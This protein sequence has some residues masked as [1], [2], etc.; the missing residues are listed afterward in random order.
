[1]NRIHSVT[2]ALATLSAAWLAAAEPAEEID[3]LAGAPASGVWKSFSEN[4]AESGGV[5]RVEDGVLHCKGSP[6]GYWYTTENYGNFI[7]KLEWRWPT[8]PG[9]GGVL[10]RTSPPHQI[11]PKSLEA[12]IN[13][14]QAGDFW[15]LG[16][17]RLTGPEERLKTADHPQF[18]KLTNLKRAVAAER[19]AGQWNQYEI[20][21][22]GDTV[23]L[24]INGQEVNRATGCETAPGAICLTAE[25]NPIEYR[26]VRLTRLP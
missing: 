14:G 20:R 7:L 24:I 2:F 4:P 8:E 17:Y 13:A 16:G 15:G 11:W 9:N 18:G 19:P 26:N 5:W 6:K 12:Q 25:G 10:V 1:M 21:A 3:L 22:E 23:T